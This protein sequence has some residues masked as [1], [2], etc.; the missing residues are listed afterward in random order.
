MLCDTQ[1]N[2][3]TFLFKHFHK[4]PPLLQYIAMSDFLCCLF[5]HLAHSCHVCC[6]SE[7]SR[8]DIIFSMMSARP[9]KRT[10]KRTFVLLRQ[11]DSLRV[12]S[13]SELKQLT[14]SER[15]K[16]LVFT[17]AATSRHVMEIIANNFPALLT[18]S[19]ISR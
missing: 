12:P 18:N 3:R 13:T 17:N 8:E 7:K 1:Y 14:A 15:V 10:L 5:K 6:K 4:G 2:F 19:N 9:R 11:D 16:E